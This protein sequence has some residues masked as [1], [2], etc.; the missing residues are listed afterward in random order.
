MSFGKAT[1]GDYPQRTEQEKFSYIR[2]PLLV[3]G[4][5]PNEEAHVCCSFRLLACLERIK[6]VRLFITNLL[7]L[8]AASRKERSGATSTLSPRART[9]SRVNSIRSEDETGL[10]HLSH[11]SWAAGSGSRMA[12]LKANGQGQRIK[13]MGVKIGFVISSGEAGQFTM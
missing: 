10:K 13:R 3:S 8:K 5:T 7:S 11:S 1:S 6:V 9:D 2:H 12:W 4:R